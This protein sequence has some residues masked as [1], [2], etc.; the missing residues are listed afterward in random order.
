M[1]AIGLFISACRSQEPAAADDPSAIL[2]RALQ[3]A[4]I[5]AVL[6][7]RGGAHLSAKTHFHVE[8]TQTPE[9]FTAQDITT[10]TEAWV[11]GK[12]G[13]RFVEENDHDGGR[14]VTAAGSEIAIGLRYGKLMRR[15][16]REGE[17]ADLL[18]Q[19]LGGPLSGWDL[20]AGAAAVEAAGKAEG[21]TAGLTHVARYRISLDADRAAP[22][23]D[24]QASPRPGIAAWRS[25]ARFETVSG[26][27]LVARPDAA[28][29]PQAAAGALVGAT[30]AVTFTAWQG[31][32]PV[33]AAVDVSFAVDQV[34][35]APEVAISEDAEALWIGQRTLPVENKLLDNLP[36]RRDPGDVS[37]P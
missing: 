10:G 12:G 18:A 20:I 25:T 26:E 13:F 21:A 17:A 14:E 6:R 31:D 35:G 34:G 19:A 33:R 4:A 1:A 8:A 37:T 36:G 29:D 9:A 3:P 23:R 32:V 11:D 2:T 5:A 22:A 7:A 28:A 24:D 16:A 30:L 15:P 27:L